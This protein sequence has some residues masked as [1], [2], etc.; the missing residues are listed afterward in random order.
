MI[1]C[2]LGL[3]LTLI[4]TSSTVVVAPTVEAVDCRSVDS[5][6]PQQEPSKDSSVQVVVPGPSQP[7]Q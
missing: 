1:V 7:K 5:P 4:I 6:T 3:S 2:S